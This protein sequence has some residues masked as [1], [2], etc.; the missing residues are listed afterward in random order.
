MLKTVAIMEDPPL[1]KM[2]QS[3]KLVQT[4]VE[5]TRTPGFLCINWRNLENIYFCSSLSQSQ[6]FVRF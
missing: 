5:D 2:D 1:N 3:P 6:H 4:F